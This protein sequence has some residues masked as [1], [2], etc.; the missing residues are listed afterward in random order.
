MNTQEFNEEEIE[1]AKKVSESYLKNN[2][3]GIESVEFESDFSHP[4][5]GMM[6]RGTVNNEAGFSISMDTELFEVMSI[7]E[8]EGFPEVKEECKEKICDY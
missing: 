8:K 4:M 1:K 5:G 6:V 2:Y 3:K 7:G